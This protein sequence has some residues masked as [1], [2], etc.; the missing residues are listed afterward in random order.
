MKTTEITIFKRP[1][2]KNPIFI[3]GLPGVGYIG[4]NVAGYLIDTLK[5]E[6]FAE[7]HSFHFPPVAMLDS[8]KNGKMSALKNEFYFYRAKNRDEQDMII[9]IGDAQSMDPIGH[10]EISRE[11]INF[12]KEFRPKIVMTL[13][14]FATGKLDNKKQTVFGAAV[15]DKIIKIFEKKGIKFK[16]TN[17][18]Q[19][20]GA[21]GLIVLEAEKN[22]IDSVCLMGETSGMLLSDPKATESVLEFITK[23]LNLKI[24]MSKIEEKVKE[25]GDV[26]K[27]IE[28]LQKKLTTQ[29]TP[30]SSSDD[31]HL[32]YIG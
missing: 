9:L 3:E 26:I 10:Y 15:K 2:L 13:G 1:E 11:V 7:L 14:G 24:D 25:T 22:N 4:R 12:I 32:G 8:E 18:G 31:E 23:Y 17:I 21:S 6:K 16:D 28:S 27:K 30:E 19:I 5:A 29:S 20:I